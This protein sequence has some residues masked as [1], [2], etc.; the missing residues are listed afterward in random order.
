MEI[1]I[2]NCNNINEATIEIALNKLNIKYGINGTGKSTISQAIEIAI[3]G[4]D[5]TKLKPF[6]TENDITP[7]IEGLEQISSIKIYN[8][9]YVSQYL[10]LPNDLHQNSFEVFIKPSNY[11]ESI[12]RINSILNIVKNYVIE[13]EV[14]NHLITQKSELDKI[15]KLNKAKTSI[16]DTGVGK[17]LN[18]GNKIINIPDELNTFTQFIN[19]ENKANWYGWQ[20]EGKQYIQN[21]KCPFCT[22][23]LIDNFED[24][25]QT[26][27]E[28]FDKKNVENI[29]KTNDI[30]NNL[31]NVIDN[32]SKEFLNNILS[33]EQPISDE[34]KERLAKFV[35]EL[36]NLCSKLQYFMQLDYSNLKSI[37][38]L[39]QQLIL[40]KINIEDIEYCKGNDFISLVNGINSKIDELLSNIQDLR[41]AIG[42]LNTSIRKYTTQNK[43]R[44]ND[45]LDTVG[46]QYEIG[47]ENNKLLLLYKGSSVIVDVKKHLSW[48]EKNVFALSL[49][50][51]D[52]L[53]DNPSLIILDD[54]VSSFDFNKKFAITYYLF[55]HDNSLK[56]KTVLML[57]HDLEPIINIIKLKKYSHVQCHYLNNNHGVISEEV[58][59]EHDINS[60]INVT[61][62]NYTNEDMNVINR[63]IHL[64]RY[65]ELNEEYDFEYNM[66]SSLLKGYD[67]PKYIDR[68]NRI[69]RVFTNEEIT[70]TSEKISN[71]IVN[72]D[73]DTIKNTIKNK[74]I[75]KQAYLDTDNNYEKIEIFR[76]LLKSNGLLNVNPVVE[77]FI[78]EAF[79]IENTY[80]FQL[81]PYAYNLVPYY[82]VDMC[83]AIINRMVIETDVTS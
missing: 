42:E 31:S 30:V 25:L 23:T 63:I 54:P 35:V 41:V 46:M 15:L 38:D 13:N 4:G 8:E 28:L 40:L 19:N 7:F 76:I 26:L 62:Q 52:C 56:N 82:I 51:F 77:K 24:L 72:F 53:Y 29:L 68:L 12:E 1:T 65:L 36:E 39:E 73:Y 69:N 58:I 57:T 64:R 59:L 78:N 5:L 44:I 3:K 61:K 45:F 32:Q 67:V 34:D 2:R 50:L 70:S 14:S 9:D 6:N 21:N 17:A 79:H 60:I 22:T 83:T 37:D 81:D 20:S 10:F 66:I 71:C 16:N 48:G 80:I 74:T 49:F 47:I 18:T 43:A 11:E 33:N 55:N 75:M 27:D